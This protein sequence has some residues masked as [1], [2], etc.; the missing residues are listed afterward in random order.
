[1]GDRGNHTARERDHRDKDSKQDKENAR[2]QQYQVIRV[3]G[4]GAYGM[5][6]K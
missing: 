4:E 6:L 1:M 2:S 3:I 5:V